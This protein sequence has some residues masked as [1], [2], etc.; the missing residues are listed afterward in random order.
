MRS[1][2]VTAGA[3]ILIAACSS[4]PPPAPVMVTS[5]AAG[6]LHALALKSDGSVW[7]W[8]SDENAQ[9]GYPASYNLGKVPIAVPGMQSGVVAIAAGEDL[10]LALKGDGSVWAWGFGER[11]QL[12]DGTKPINRSTPKR[13]SSLSGRFT[14]IA[15]GSEFALAL[16][17]DGT[18]WAWGDGVQGQLGNGAL[19]DSDSAVQVVGLSHVTAIAAGDNHGLAVDADGSLWGWGDNSYRELGMPTSANFQSTAVRVARIGPVMAVAGGPFQT[20]VI[21]R[22]GEVFGWGGLF[23]G[24]GGQ[25]GGPGEPFQVAGHWL[26]H[27]KQVQAAWGVDFALDSDG[28]VWAWGQSRTLLGT[29]SPW[30][31]PLEVPG[32]ESGINSISAIKLTGYAI[33]SKGHVLAWGDNSQGQ[34]GNGT[35]NWPEPGPSTPVGVNSF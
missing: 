18:V 8:G 21:T 13:V 15:A 16:R 30:N 9:L 28:T 12:G 34:I 23:F 31:Q 27:P 22:A 19:A 20:V 14:S 3:L 6:S 7:A 11:G 2:L 10:S 29:D 25:P 17:S 35:Q 24:L 32:L 5:V 4:T 1:P 26:S 33:T